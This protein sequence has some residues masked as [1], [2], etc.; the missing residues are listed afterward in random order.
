MIFNYKN[1]FI[2]IYYLI[3][4]YVLEAFIFPFFG[5]YNIVWM[6]LYL[7]DF[8]PNFYMEKPIDS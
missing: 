2:H 7:H 8:S 1:I 3:I 5:Y 4:P 6:C